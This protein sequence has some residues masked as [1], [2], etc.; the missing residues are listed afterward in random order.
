MDKN[1]FLHSKNYY[2]AIIS[3]ADIIK[4]KGYWDDVQ[5]I[6]ESV[7]E[8]ILSVFLTIFKKGGSKV[9]SDEALLLSAVLNRHFS[10]AIV[11]EIIRQGKKNLI[12]VPTYLTACIKMDLFQSTAYS[13]KL[14]NYIKCMGLIA[15]AIDKEVEPEEIAFLTAYIDS[16]EELVRRFGIKQKGTETGEMNTK[17]FDD[18]TSGQMLD[19]L[20]VMCKSSGYVLSADAERSAIKYF[21]EKQEE[22]DNC[23]G[24]ARGVRNY[25][26]STISRQASRIVNAPYHDDKILMTLEAVDFSES[27]AD[28]ANLKGFEGSKYLQ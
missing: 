10:K 23:F 27:V 9:D 13:L 15:A 21:T 3:I 6:T 5:P 4:E 18:Y 11:S 19:I 17:D 20:K 28:D 24:N 22:N 7:D 16:M 1:L 26:E 25:L 8:H 2:E 12:Q 14:V